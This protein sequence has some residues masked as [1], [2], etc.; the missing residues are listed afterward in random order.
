MANAALALAMA[1]AAGVP[2]AEMI[3]GIAQVAVPGRMERV[4]RGQDFIALVDYA[5]KPAAVAA[6]LDTLRAQR[7]PGSRIGVVIGAGGDRDAAKREL[8]GQAAA[9]RADLVVVTD[10][11]P[12]SEEPAAIRQ[13]VL[14]GAQRERAAGA[15]VHLEEIGHR[16]AAIDYAVR[17]AQPGDI[18]IVVGK[19]HEQG[20]IIGDKVID[21]DDR[22]ELARA[23]EERGDNAR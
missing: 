2:A 12:R 4:D 11:N 21:F 1:Q 22:V 10:D 14:S 5:H 16:A 7:Q 8:M 15:A 6:V 9:R 23:I 20:Q 3:P 13:A 19:G 18:V 17:W